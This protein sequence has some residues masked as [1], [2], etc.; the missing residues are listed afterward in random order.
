MLQGH[1]IGVV[2][3]GEHTHHLEL[4]VLEPLVLQHLLYRHHL[5]TS[6]HQM[7]VSI[8]QKK[9]VP[10]TTTK[11][12]SHLYDTVLRNMTFANKRADLF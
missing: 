12:K 4:P 1:D 9:T 8:I 7:S 5:H 11:E 3:L 6:K 10:S 2:L